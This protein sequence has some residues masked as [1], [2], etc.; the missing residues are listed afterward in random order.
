MGIKIGK[1]TKIG[2]NNAIGE[3][4]S[5]RILKDTATHKTFVERHPILIGLFCSL[6]A[7]V[8]LMFKFWSYIISW[9]EGLF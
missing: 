1:E 5:V 4:A 3:N 8:F 9:F 2:D 6:V 7:G